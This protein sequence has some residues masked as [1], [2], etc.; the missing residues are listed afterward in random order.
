[1]KRCIIVFLL[2]LSAVASWVLAQSFDAPQTRFGKQ[3]LLITSSGLFEEG[4]VFVSDNFEADFPFN[5]IG[6][7]WAGQESPPT[8]FFIAVDDGSWKEMKMVGGE[9]K[10][11]EKKNAFYSVPLFEGGKTFS[12]KIVAPSMVESVEVLYFNTEKESMSTVFFGAKRK[13]LNNPSSVISREAW[14]ADESWNTWE[15]EYK[16]VEQFI[17]HH[18]AGGDGGDDPAATIRGIY[19]WHA[20]VLGWGDI[21][22]NYIMDQNGNIY[23][24]RYGGDGVIGGHTYNDQKGIN[25]NEG[26][27]GIAILGCYE[28]T[29]G[30]C[31]SSTP[32]NKELR[33]VLSDFFAG[34][35]KALGLDPG[36]KD[37]FI[38]EEAYNVIGHRDVDAT[39]CPG[40]VLW[41][42]LKRVREQAHK[43]YLLLIEQNYV[44]EIS[45]KDFSTVVYTEESIPVTIAY[46]NRGEEA[47]VQDEVALRWGNTTLPL[48]RESIAPGE[49]AV[50]ALQENLPAH[51]GRYKK[52][53]ELIIGKSVIKGSRANIEI[54]VKPSRKAKFVS[55]NL[56]P[57]I[58][59]TWRPTFQI[60]Y[61]NAGPKTWKN[62]ELR[63]N[64][65]LLASSLSPVKKGEDAV[66]TFTLPEDFYTSGLYQ[67]IFS[68]RTED[69]SVKDSRKIF[70]MNVHE[71]K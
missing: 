5:G 10:A 22:Y 71:V 11:S 52:T 19:F 7:H 42:K 69:H 48:P 20:V 37:L 40:D 49:E 29:E 47:W 24:G 21:G 32:Y 34:K 51:R 58:L 35:G 33:S 8:T 28:T 65:V 38:D 36:K 61:N 63:V 3:M 31:S 60:I 62:P 57:A 43:K 39:Y 67:L 30:A 64:D 9:S 70:L 14:G 41:K 26:S 25:Y 55:S 1:M 6:I 68:L 15:P 46:K 4:S 13:M 53:A 45:Q 16:P 50:F 27:L 59:E 18:T 23:E 66:F 44:A 12:L 17:V 56:P 54:R 2:F